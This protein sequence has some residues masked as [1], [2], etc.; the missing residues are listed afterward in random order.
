VFSSL[1]LG[2][3]PLEL[4]TDLGALAAFF[5]AFLLLTVLTFRYERTK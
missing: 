1:V 2:R 5:G 3:G 4:G